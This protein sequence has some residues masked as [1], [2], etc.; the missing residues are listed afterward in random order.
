MT[1]RFRGAHAHSIPADMQRCNALMA[2]ER[3]RVGKQCQPD[4]GYIPAA[5]DVLRRCRCHF[6]SGLA[7]ND[8]DS[9][10]G[11]EAHTERIQA[12]LIDTLVVA[13]PATAAIV[14]VAAACRKSGLHWVD[15][16]G[17]APLRYRAAAVVAAAVAMRHT[18]G[19]S[20]GDSSIVSKRLA[21][22]SVLCSAHPIGCRRED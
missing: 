17:P 18:L 19:R 9:G 6:R 16:A 21:S 22:H 10:F 3:G 20:I 13:A 12:L 15:S 4:E 11:T 1:R 5:L 7:S 8:L 14:S 2:V